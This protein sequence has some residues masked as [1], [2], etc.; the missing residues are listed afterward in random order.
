[1][2]CRAG[3]A[4]AVKAVQV[5]WNKAEKAIKLAEQVNGEIINPAVYELRYAGRRLVE[6][7]VETDESN[8]R[9]LLADASFDCCRA[10]HD[11]IDAATSKIVA[12]LDIAVARIGAEIVLHSFPEYCDLVAA[13]GDIRDRIAVSRERRGD[14][15]VI[16]SSIEKDLLEDIVSRF[17]KFRASE[18]LMVAVARSQRRSRLF[19]NIFGW[20]GVLVTIFVAYVSKAQIVA[21]VEAIFNHP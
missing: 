15:D 20:T 13:L 1:M 21:F 3:L 11:A 19:N 5:E 8:A 14:R 9:K 12:D 2:V 10:R 17:R 18:P 4:E 16:Y 6:A 7:L